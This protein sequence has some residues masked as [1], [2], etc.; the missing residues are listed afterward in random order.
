MSLLVFIARRELLQCGCRVVTRK[1][2][3]KVSRSNDLFT[4]VVDHCT[5]GYLCTAIFNRI[6]FQS[7][8]YWIYY[9]KFTPVCYTFA[10]RGLFIIIIIIK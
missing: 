6:V 7:Y 8:I 2:T 3:Y 5:Y 1:T 10:V 9:Y 4:T